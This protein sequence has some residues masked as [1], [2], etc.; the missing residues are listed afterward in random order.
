MQH[1]NLFRTLAVPLAL[2]TVLLGIPAGVMEVLRDPRPD[3]ISHVVWIHNI[4]DVRCTFETRATTEE[5]HQALRAA[6]QDG[7]WIAVRRGGT[8]H[9]QI[10]TLRGSS[11]VGWDI[12]RRLMRPA[13]AEA[14]IWG[15]IDH[16]TSQSESPLT[17]VAT[18]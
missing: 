14:T 16:V 3:V 6:Q 1:S 9:D 13:K 8:F 15:S 17:L 12:D 11:I 18:H 4:D 10:T 5:I 2:C 7:G